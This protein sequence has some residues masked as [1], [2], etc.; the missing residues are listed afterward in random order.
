MY[1]PNLSSMSVVEYVDFL[2]TRSLHMGIDAFDLNIE[3]GITMGIISDD[4]YERAKGELL[5]RWA[6]EELFGHA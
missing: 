6:K 5:R 2:E 1:I 3:Y 4:R